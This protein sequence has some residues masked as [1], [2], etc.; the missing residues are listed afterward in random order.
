MRRT[1]SAAYGNECPA[2]YF[3][4]FASLDGKRFRICRP[5]GPGNQQA[6]AY[7]GY[8][9]YHNLGFQSIVG[10]NGM[11]LQFSGPFAG[12]GNDLDMLAESRSLDM[13]HEALED[14]QLDVGRFDILADKIYPQVRGNGIVSLR[15][16]QYRHTRVEE[17][18]DS[19][20]A[21]ACVHVEHLFA[22][23]VN[24][25]PFL[26]FSKGLKVNEREIGRY[27]VVGALIINLHTCLYGSQVC[28]QFSTDFDII[29]PPTLEEYM[30]V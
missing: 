6:G 2:R 22:K 29:L 1:I 16:N 4:C 17:E 27:M 26:D 18:E 20:A 10:P 3:N 15:Q 9:G 30:A 8:Y 13:M 19:A 21:S 12:S 24:L 23:M 25:L 14:G 11:F 5:S 28:A 7:N